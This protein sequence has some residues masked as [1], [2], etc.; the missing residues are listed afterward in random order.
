MPNSPASPAVSVLS[1]IDIVELA[2]SYRRK[3][4]GGTE[5]HQNS[6]VFNIAY[7]FN[8]DWTSWNQHDDRFFLKVK[9]AFFIDNK[10]SGSRFLWFE[11]NATSLG[12]KARCCKQPKLRFGLCSRRFLQANYEKYSK[13]NSLLPI[14]PMSGSQLELSL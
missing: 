5:K 14:T 12:I 4:F 1:L 13:T 6:M 10:F 2:E 8:P 3:S 9:V 11:V 7:T